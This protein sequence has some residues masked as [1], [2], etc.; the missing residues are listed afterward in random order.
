[1]LTK[2]RSNPQFVSHYKPR[3]KRAVMWKANRALHAGADLFDACVE[4]AAL[5]RERVASCRVSTPLLECESF[6]T[7]L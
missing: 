4:R 5:W 2:R 3:V 6:L 1:M 7:N